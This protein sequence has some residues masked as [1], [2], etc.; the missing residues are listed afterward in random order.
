VHQVSCEAGVET[1][2]AELRLRPSG[3]GVVL[4][5]AQ[6]TAR[7]QAW[8]MKIAILGSTGFLGKVLLEKALNAGY[9][10]RSFNASSTCSI[11]P[12]RSETFGFPR[13]TDWKSYEGTSRVFMRSAST[14]SI[15]SYSRSAMGT[16]TT[17]GSSTI[18]RKKR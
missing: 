9:Q 15:G 13:T 17:S 14:T 16:R 5:I 12:P 18:T 7:T 3:R 4:G 2:T 11:A 6:V 8:Q 1:A 10:V